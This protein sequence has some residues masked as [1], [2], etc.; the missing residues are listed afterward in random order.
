MSQERGE[1]VRAAADAVIASLNDAA[2][3]VFDE[4]G[5]KLGEGGVALAEGLLRYV[6]SMGLHGASEGE[7]RQE[8]ATALVNTVLGFWSRNAAAY[9]KGMANAEQIGRPH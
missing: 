4:L 6:I 2:P 7:N 5:L 8:V 1:L 9:V 3:A